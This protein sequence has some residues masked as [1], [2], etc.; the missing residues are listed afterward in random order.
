MNELIDMVVDRLF[1]NY[2]RC[3]MLI[4]FSEGSV[5]SYLMNNA[6]V[7]NTEYTENGTLIDIECRLSQYNKYKEYVK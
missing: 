4:P 1:K 3:N 7:L 2:K 6:N 5:L